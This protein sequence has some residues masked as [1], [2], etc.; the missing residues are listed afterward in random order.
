MH[1]TVQIGYGI[2]RE[3]CGFPDLSGDENYILG[4]ELSQLDV[5]VSSGIPLIGIPIHAENL[6]K[7]EMHLNAA[8][9]RYFY[10]FFHD[11]P[12]ETLVLLF[13]DANVDARD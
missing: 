3:L 8:G 4:Y 9:R 1:R 11:D 5:L 7:I 6:P 13:V 12:T 10:R 2:T